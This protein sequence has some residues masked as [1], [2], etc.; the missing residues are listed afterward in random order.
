MLIGV[1]GAAQ[2]GK[3]SV[4]NMLVANYGYTKLAF[5]DGV[6]EMAAAIDPYVDCGAD[7]HY[8]AGNSPFARYSDVLREIG[9]ERAKQTPDVRRLLQRIGTEAVRDVFGEHAWIELAQRRALRLP[10]SANIVFS[11]VRFANEA[12]FIRNNGG[13][14]VRV[15]RPGHDNGLPATHASESQVAGLDVDAELEATNLDELAGSVQLF[16]AS[17]GGF[18]AKLRE[19]C[20]EESGAPLSLDQHDFIVTYSGQRVNVFDLRPSD[21]NILDIAHALSLLCRFTGHCSRFYSVAQHA[22]EMSYLVPP[23]FALEAL[24]HDSAEAYVN[25]LSRPLKHHPSMS[26]Y[27]DAEQLVDRA[28]RA[29]FGLPAV[30]T[31]P[32]MSTEVK[33]ADNRL[34]CTEARQLLR[35]ANWSNGHE[36]FDHMLRNIG[37]E[38]MERLFLSRFEELTGTRVEHMRNTTQPAEPDVQ[39][40]S[41]EHAVTIVPNDHESADA[42]K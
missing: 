30:E 10:D 27:L 12:A 38:E 25:D 35:D 17:L 6:R 37:P 16:M 26:R 3:D 40:Q 20:E 42:A 34:V 31:A 2:A 11:D 22:W 4:A 36:A 28:V 14:V 18:V 32:Y 41:S 9:Y 19:I 5:A 21:V 13:V 8:T 24:L 7:R 33:D 39:Y 23:A 29:H 15:L 1:T